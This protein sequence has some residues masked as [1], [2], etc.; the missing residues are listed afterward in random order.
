MISRVFSFLRSALVWLSIV[1]FSILIGAIVLGVQGNDPNQFTSGLVTV[2]GI[3]AVLTGLGYV[4]A[5]SLEGEHRAWI[6]RESG[7]L[8]SGTLFWFY[9]ALAQYGFSFLKTSKGSPLV[10]WLNQVINLGY[11]GTVGLLALMAAIYTLFAASYIVD[12]LNRPQA[13]ERLEQA[14]RP[15]GNRVMQSINSLLH[16]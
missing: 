12:Y 7:N 8:F 16:R 14:G 4:L 9:A 11:A 3:T 1:L 6:N 15:R 2:G 13:I 5:Q 10:P